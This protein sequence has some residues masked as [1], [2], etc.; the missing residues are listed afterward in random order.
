MNHGKERNGRNGLHQ[1]PGKSFP[2]HGT[3]C[4]SRSV[5][6]S[7]DSTNTE[8]ITTSKS[9]LGA[10]PGRVHTNYTIQCILADNRVY[11]K[12]NRCIGVAHLHHIQKHL[13][14]PGVRNGGGIIKPVPR[15]KPWPN[16][17]ATSKINDRCKERY[18]EDSTFENHSPPSHQ[19]SN[20][21]RSN[22]SNDFRNAIIITSLR[23]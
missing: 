14:L 1:A 19:I 20:C 17:Y 4:Y 12:K 8:D 5:K 9:C 13:V 3:V 6:V 11:I 23:D 18:D 21:S 22:F 2:C 10:A 7:S 16:A 15:Q